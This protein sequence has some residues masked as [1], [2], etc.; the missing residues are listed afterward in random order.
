MAGRRSI[1]YP[2]AA[3]DHQTANARAF[4]AEAACIVIPHADFTVAA[5]A[6]HLTALFETPQRL[7]DMASAA[8]AAGRPDA[9]ARLADMVSE[10]IAAPFPVASRGVPA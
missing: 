1:P 8:H 7:A 10:L 5:L 3:D 2:H 6:G 9:A 4:E